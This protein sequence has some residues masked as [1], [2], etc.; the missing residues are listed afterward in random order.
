MGRGQRNGRVIFSE[1]TRR[2]GGGREEP[3]GEGAV[4]AALHVCTVLPPKCTTSARW[5]KTVRGH[6]ARP[7]YPLGH[8]V[9]VG[10]I[11]CPMGARSKL[12][13]RATWNRRFLRG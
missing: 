8:F 4:G 13:N 2:A 9:F 12:T 7:V 10:Q 5:V 1:V 6:F 3:V 11:V